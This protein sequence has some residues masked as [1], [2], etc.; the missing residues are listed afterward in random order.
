MGACILASKAA[1]RTGLG[2]LTAHIPSKGYSAIQSSVPEAM[3]SIDYDSKMFT[4]L[5]KLTPYNTVGIGPGLGVHK[6]SNE[7]FLKLLKSGIPLVIDADGLNMLAK[8]NEW[9]KHIPEDSILTPHPKEFDRLTGKSKNSYERLQK[10]IKL[11]E[12]LKSIIVLKG[13]YTSVA[14]PNGKVFF[15]TTG[16][17]GMATGGSGDVLTGIILGF[18]AQ[19][20]LSEEAAMAGVFIHGLA[21]DIAAERMS[22]ASLIASDI[23]EA[24]PEAFLMFEDA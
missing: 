6:A 14:L 18:T 20:F 15:N 21:G 5:P 12:E 22:Q 23:I 8:N 2:L 10:Q 17:P 13:H 19:G 24:L 7:A 1:L 16:N 4:R 9:L 11:A 3:V